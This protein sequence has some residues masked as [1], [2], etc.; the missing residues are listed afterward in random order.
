VT[1]R[2]NQSITANGSTLYEDLAPG[3]Y[4]VSLSGVAA[5]CVV[6]D[7][8][9]RLVTVIAGP[10]TRVSFVVS[11]EALAGGLQVT[12]VTTGED[13]DPDGYTVT[14]D[15]TISQSIGP[16][17]TIT[18]ASLSAGT[19]S[20]ELTGV[21]DN[22]AV[23]GSNPRDVSIAAGGSAQTTFSIE[24]TSLLG[25]LTVTAVTTGEDPDPDGYTATLDNS[26]SQALAPSGNTTFASIQAGTHT[27]E[28]SGVASNCRVNGDN[29]QTA[30]VPEGG[31]ASVTFSVLCDLTTG[32]IE[33]TVEE[34]GTDLDPD[35]YEVL[36]DGAISKQVA[37]RDTAVYT[38]VNP[39]DHSLQLSGLADNCTVVGS[40]PTTITVTAGQVSRHRFAI[41]CTSPVGT[42]RV[43]ASTTGSSLDP[44]GYVAS[45]DGGQRTTRIDVDGETGF[46]N[47]TAGEHEVELLDV[48]ENCQVFGDNPRTETVV[49]GQSVTVTFAVECGATV[50]TIR[51][52]ANTTGQDIDPNGY[53]AEIDGGVRTTRIDANGETGF[54]NLLPGEHSVGITDVASNC[55]VLGQN[56]RSVTLNAGDNTL[57]T[58]GVEC[59]QLGPCV[60]P[61]P[62][63]VSWW[64][65]DGDASD[66]AGTNGGTTLGEVEYETGFVAT[67][68]G[69]AFSFPGIN[70]DAEV[71]VSSNPDLNPSTTNGFT[72]EAWVRSNSSDYNGGVVSKGAVS[73][74]EFVLDQHWGQWRAFMRNAG[75]GLVLVSAPMT[76][77][78]FTH[79][80]MT[81]NGVQLSL[82]VNGVLSD[83][84]AVGTIN[85]TGDYL[86]IGLRNESGTEDFQFEF[87]GLIDDVSYYSRAL[88]PTEIADIVEAGDAGKC[89][90]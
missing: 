89:R 25:S 28:L 55:A 90:G 35:G 62:G 21:A 74:E 46:G 44:D 30:S 19:H 43:G 64:A 58:F 75:G 1:G 13:P 81:W 39:G 60:E 76:A 7:G 3:E 36:L 69:E 63:L 8:R 15:G 24:C 38:G 41:E 20:V 2:E 82:Y 9:T 23:A 87:D 47:L 85:T 22:C 51:V 56:P 50:G 31:T 65:A 83:Q 27:V 16:A 72:V 79:P 78:V 77:G 5:N 67:G 26:T 86:R 71:R 73:D 18:F 17:G 40:N 33:V 70:G 11:C 49:G 53:V 29:P 14:I 48:A 57:V 37:S 4:T 52:R 6:A 32:S 54:G 66:I 88:S 12:S 80:A 84:A 45:I 61:P 34:S 42:L 59:V 68:T 10:T